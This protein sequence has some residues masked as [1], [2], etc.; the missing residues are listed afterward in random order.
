MFASYA[1]Y[2]TRTPVHRYPFY[3]RRRVLSNV[4]AS[5]LDSAAFP[6][7]HHGQDVF[8]FASRVSA[9]PCQEEAAA[10]GTARLPLAVR[11]RSH[12]R[13]RFIS[14]LLMVIPLG[15]TFLILRLLYNLTA[16]LLAPL[17][18]LLFGPLPEAVVA[19]ASLAALLLILYGIGTVSALVVGRRLLALAD[20][21][22]RRLPVVRPIYGAVKQMVGSLSPKGPDQG[23]FQ[24][25]AFVEYPRPGLKAIGFITGVERRSDGR[26]YC[27]VLLPC[28]LN[29]TSAALA[30]IPNEE[31]ERSDLSV[32]E[33]MRVLLSGG[34]LAPTAKE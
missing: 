15:I 17:M 33:A 3:H 16:G 23:A 2:D 30:F 18:P 21:L 4:F 20:A 34:L 32:D 12:L 14:G 25:V 19:V 8:A 31:V 6:R 13:K 22:L 1:G 24:G 5:G 9:H 10:M 11:L 26:E 27:R 28:A 7:H 29:P